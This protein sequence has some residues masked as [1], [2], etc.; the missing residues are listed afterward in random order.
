MIQARDV[1]QAVA[2]DFLPGDFRQAID[3]VSRA[4]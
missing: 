3:A 2:A 4:S 1:R